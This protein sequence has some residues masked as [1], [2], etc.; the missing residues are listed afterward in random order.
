MN[1]GIAILFLQSFELFLQSKNN[2]RK[3]R[4]RDKHLRFRIAT[5]VV[6]VVQNCERSGQEETVLN[7]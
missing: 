5:A 1:W 4:I 2:Q 7:S 3:R 6:E